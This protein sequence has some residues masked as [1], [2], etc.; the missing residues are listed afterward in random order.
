MY[1]G[2]TLFMKISVLMVDIGGA[3]G[4]EVHIM[5]HKGNEE[6][7]GERIV[8]WYEPIAPK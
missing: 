6:R 4:R 7:M 1:L 3:R 8:V 2:H 5:R